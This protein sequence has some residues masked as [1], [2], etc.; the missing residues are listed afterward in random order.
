M[1]VTVSEYFVATITFFLLLDRTGVG[2]Y[3]VAA[4][5]LHEMGHI[6]ALAL[7]RARPRALRFTAFGIELQKPP[8]QLRTSGELFFAAAGPAVNLLCAALGFYLWPQRPFFWQCHLTVALFNLLP[9]DPLDGGRILSYILG[10]LAGPNCAERVLKATTFTFS[11]AAI[12]AGLWILR[13]QFQFTLLLVV[14]YIA[15]A[16]LRRKV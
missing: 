7:L 16:F 8:A 15:L 9:V 6:A 11:I 4:C 2:I 14:L 10:A 1:P 12:L 5:L 13:R 3:A